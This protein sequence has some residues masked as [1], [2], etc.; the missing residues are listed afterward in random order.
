VAFLLLRPG[1]L[2]KLFVK[3]QDSFWRKETRISGR[4]NSS[5]LGHFCVFIRFLVR[6]FFAFTSEETIGGHVRCFFTFA[7][8]SSRAFK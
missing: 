6:N 7:S 5:L 1:F 2:P 4:R 3:I 8:L